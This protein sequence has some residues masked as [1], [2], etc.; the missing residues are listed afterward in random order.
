[1]DIG[2]SCRQGMSWVEGGAREEER[3]CCSLGSRMLCGWQVRGL[4]AGH[5]PVASGGRPHRL[6]VQAAGVRPK[7][8]PPPGLGPRVPLHRLSRARPSPEEA[9]RLRPQ[10][11]AK[12]YLEHFPCHKATAIPSR[13]QLRDG[14]LPWGAQW[15]CSQRA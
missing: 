6:C 5:D 8:E 13:A 15:D 2:R 3:L 14:D 10:S 9:G 1:M 11:A 4:R 7:T 12:L